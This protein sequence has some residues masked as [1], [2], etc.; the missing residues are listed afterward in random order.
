MI[1][2]DIVDAHVHIWDINR[3]RYPWLDDN[4]FLNRTFTLV[5]Y[6]EA[7]G[8]VKVGK[9]VFMQCECEP[10]Q[11][12]DEVEWAEKLAG[13]EKRIKGIVPWAPLEK[14]AAVEEELAEMSKNPLIKGIRRIIQFEPDMEFCLRPDFITGVN[15]LPKYNFTFDICIDYR[16]NRNT[17]R[18][19]EKLDGV[20]C[21]IDHIGKPGIKDGLLDPWRSEMKQLAAF[22]NVYCKVS[23]LAT[24][25]DHAHWTTEGLRPYVDC[26]FENFGF[27]RTMFAG[28]WPVS[29]QAADYRTCVKTLLSFVEGAPH[30]DI[31]RLFRKNAEEFYKV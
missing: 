27:D 11:H 17:L 14:G 2:F 28:D 30:D 9:M 12:L 31:Y 23:S 21:V 25:A 8:D 18:F 29:A 5:D 10:A 16:H 20:R 26:I 3:L 15:L 7:C 19:L 13:Q 4:P 1:D 22:P 24:E 6:N